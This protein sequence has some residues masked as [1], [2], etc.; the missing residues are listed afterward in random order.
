LPTA[1]Y[2]GQTEWYEA[3]TSADVFSI[4]REFAVE[5]LGRGAAESREPVALHALLGFV[6]AD[7]RTS[8]LSLRERQRQTEPA[9]ESNQER[10][11]T[12]IRTHGDL[13][14]WDG[15]RRPYG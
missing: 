13:A 4:L 1:R 14:Y 6:H 15:A 10:S 7:G 5:L 3:Y 12:K 9:H 11:E 2:D 8:R